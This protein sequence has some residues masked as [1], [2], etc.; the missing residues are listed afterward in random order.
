LDYTG[1]SGF[2]S[3]EGVED[4]KLVF[5]RKKIAAHHVWMDPHVLVMNSG[6]CSA[7]FG[8]AALA[9]SFSGLNVTPREA[10]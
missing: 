5:S 3:K 6:L 1:Q 4:P 10:V 9:E 7:E 2:W 8:A